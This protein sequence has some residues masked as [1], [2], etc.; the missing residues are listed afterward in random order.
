M[1]PLTLKSAEKS[2]DRLRVMNQIIAGLQVIKMYVW[3][4]PFYNLVETARK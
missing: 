4:T 3:E 2:D 1:S